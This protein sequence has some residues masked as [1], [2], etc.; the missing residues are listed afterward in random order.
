[1]FIYRREI[2]QILGENERT[3][4]ELTVSDEYKD[5]FNKIK[6]YIEQEN[7]EIQDDTLNQEIEILN[8]LINLES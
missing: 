2:Y 8:K 4:V 7:S 6:T 5:I 3:A 1:M